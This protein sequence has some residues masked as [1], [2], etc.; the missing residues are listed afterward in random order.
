MV[1]LSFEHGLV[2]GQ[3][4]NND[5]LTSI[6]KCS[7]QGGMRRSHKTNTLLI[8]SNHLKSI[9]EDRWVGD[10]LHYTGMGMV[11][12][13]SLN[14][15][16]NKTLHE[17]PH[18]G[19]S[20]YLFEVFQDKQYT[21]RGQVE[22]ANKPYQEEQPDQDETLRKVW[23]FPLKIVD[24]GKS[25]SLD[26]RVLVKKKEIKEKQAKRLTDEELRKR[27]RYS[28]KGGVRD[29][30]T[31]T[32]DRNPYINEMAKRRADGT[33]SLCKQPAPF[34]DKKGQPFLETHHIHWL[35]QG[36]DDT[37]EN[38]VALCPNCHRKM[39][40]LNLPLDVEILKQSQKI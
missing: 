5:K 24:E 7:T 33:C 40:A 11:G 31:K 15:A 2:P 19:V 16:Q 35:S 29:I 13:Q 17:S 34:K 6:F 18:N 21:Y 10:I 38:T 32:Y 22:L 20:V 36:G 25:F 8:I 37:V 4:I 28:S 14:A 3:S 9:Y 12:S 39:H 27:A 30:S 26:E 23:V 1:K